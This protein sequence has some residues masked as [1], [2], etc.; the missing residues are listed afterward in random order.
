M[1]T[2]TSEQESCAS[3]RRRAWVYCETCEW[4]RTVRSASGASAF[5]LAEEDARVHAAVAE[6]ED[7]PHRVHAVS[8]ASGEVVVHE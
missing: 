6:Y 3:E 2:D 4:S 7:D 8:G 5:A 1:R